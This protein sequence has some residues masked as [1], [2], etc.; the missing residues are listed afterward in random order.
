[1][2]SLHLYAALRRVLGPCNAYRIA[3]GLRPGGPAK[4]AP[5]WITALGIAIAVGYVAAEGDAQ[6]EAGRQA[7]EAR[8]S[9]HW[10]GQYQCK[11]RPHH[12]ADDHT[13]VCAPAPEGPQR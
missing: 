6:A 1:M 4:A 7:E 12:W 10:A 5:N 8:A 13:P 3:R 2:I 9:R 11:G